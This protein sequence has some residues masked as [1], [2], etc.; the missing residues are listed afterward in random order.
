MAVDAEDVVAPGEGG[1]HVV[2]EVSF[3]Y[4]AISNIPVESKRGLAPR[5]RQ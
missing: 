3:D 4:W 1:R 2:H 5:T